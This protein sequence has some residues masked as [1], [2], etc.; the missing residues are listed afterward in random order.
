MKLILRYQKK[1]EYGDDIFVA[2]NSDDKPDEQPA[3]Q[4]LQGIYGKLTQKFDTFLPVYH[5]TEHEYCSIRFKPSAKRFKRGNLY[6][7]KFKITQKEKKGKNYCNCFVL[8]AKL[9]KTFKQDDG[10]E[11]TF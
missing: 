5:S 2:N 3:Y 4:E 7:V 6:T 8:S 11:L 10:E 1:S 9:F